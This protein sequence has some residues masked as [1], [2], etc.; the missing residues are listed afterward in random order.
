MAMPGAASEQP[1]NPFRWKAPDSWVQA[2]AAPARVVTYKVAPRQTVECYVAVLG[3]AA[4]GTFMNV[5]RWRSQLGQ[6]S[7]SEEQVAALRKVKVLGTEAPLVEVAGNYTDMRGEAH[8]G[9]MLLATMAP[10]DGYTVFVK[11]VGPEAEVRAERERFVQ[12]CASLE[13]AK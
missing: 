8:E 10:L 9:S 12:F 4:G 1:E 3:G 6:G 5:N 2:P 7:L 11:M 13:V